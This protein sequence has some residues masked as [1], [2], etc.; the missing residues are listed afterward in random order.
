MRNLKQQEAIRWKW[1]TLSLALALALATS[2][3]V[4]NASTYSGNQVITKNTTVAA[5]D[6][7]NPTGTEF[8]GT[9]DPIL[10]FDTTNVDYLAFGPTTMDGSGEIQIGNTSS[11]IQHLLFNGV[12]NTPLGTGTL[13]IDDEAPL[14]AA[15]TPLTNAPPADVQLIGSNPI[16]ASDLIINSNG[17]QITNPGVT[18]VIIGDGTVTEV[19]LNEL[20]LAAN[21]GGNITMDNGVLNA[22]TLIDDGNFAYGNGNTLIQ[23]SGTINATD[24]TSQDDVAFGIGG[25]GNHPAGGGL[26]GIG[27]LH[28]NVTNATMANATLWGD[29]ESVDFNLGG[30][31]LT[32][33]GNVTG[34]KGILSVGSSNYT[35]GTNPNQVVFSGY[36]TIDGNV[37]VY[38]ANST[39]TPL[40]RFEVAPDGSGLVINGNYFQ[41]GGDL[42]IPITPSVAYG[43]SDNGSFTGNGNL[44]VSGEKG[45]YTNGQT[46]HLITANFLT[47]NPSNVYYVYE[48]SAASGI[49]GL[50]GYVTKVTKNVHGHPFVQLC[51]GSRCVA[52]PAS[53]P[54]KPQPQPIAPVIPVHVVTPVQEAQPVLAD[55]PRVTQAAIQN[56]AQTLVST[57]VVGG[58]PRGLWVKGMGG[59]SREQGYD[60]MNYGLISGYG[61]SVGPDGLD[62]AGVAFSAGQAG[63]GTGPSDFTKASDYGLWAYGTYYP[64]ASRSWKITGTLGAGLSTNTL[65][66]T[67]LGLPQ[68]AHFGGGFMGTEIRASY[69]KTLPALDG[70]IVSPRLSVG[71]NQSWTS[72]YS[73]HGGGH[74]DVNVSGQTD[75]QIYLEPAILVGKKFDYRTASGRHTIFPQIRLGAVESVGPNPAAEISSGQVASQVQGLP[76]PH[77]QGMIEG[78]LDVI[79]HSRYSNGLSVNVSIRQLFG[80]GASSTEGVAAIKYHW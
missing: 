51:L 62:V 63:L 44:V 59:F 3:A 57:G 1:K 36:G 42:V 38:G 76:F 6:A 37:D 30:G 54:A 78:R 65:M 21:T 40:T 60:G 23:G 20:D 10:S 72:G 33:T 61:W 71:Y 46:Y 7:W 80:N 24:L 79:S 8:S 69:W 50:A 35:S 67:A 73:T 56:A 9:A 19:T 31:T 74:L 2:P 41:D 13:T 53:A 11:G 39:A 15:G 18:N 48:G 77:L 68:V 49:D 12:T 64:Q 32:M 26:N 43:I 58:G 66:T 47:W 34:H 4:A 27:G 25:N 5:G 55:A 75:G 28:V 22:R 45:A 17:G 29:A 70:I 14:D 16:A 52:Q